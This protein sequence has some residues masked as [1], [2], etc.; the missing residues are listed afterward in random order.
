[1]EAGFPR[2]TVVIP[3]HNRWPMLRSALWSALNQEGVDPAV[4]VVDDASADQTREALAAVE[5]ARVTVL[6]LPENSGVSAARN[7][8]LEQVA[9]EWV[10][11]LD[12]DDVWAPSHL[13]G[14]LEA[15]NAAEHDVDVVCSGSYTVTGERAVTRVRC[16]PTAARVREALRAR[17]VLV[18]PSRVLVR[19]EA[20]RAVGGFDTEFSLAA[21]WDLW[22]R[23]VQ[24]GAVAAAPA[25]SVAYTVH[26]ENMHL[27][28]P[29]ALDELARL[30]ERH[31]DAIPSGTLVRSC[32]RWIATSYRVTG[33]RRSAAEWYLRSFGSEREP[34]DLARAAG[35]L[36]GDRAT[37][38]VRRARGVP[39]PPEA[40]AW[41]RAVREIDLLP[42]EEIPF[43]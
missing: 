22:L 17:N 32:A 11:F 6:R 23:L 19:T 39:L 15:A 42:P 37:A 25:V 16:P 26:G 4:V 18:V 43:A 29:R 36:L 1:M 5:D 30:E 38:G 3:T 35:A 21:D 12:D 10:A 7:L 33:S 31:A 9:T 13:A 14:L 41:L 2:V 40:P 24:N 8:G 34:R 28:V 20:V 27:D